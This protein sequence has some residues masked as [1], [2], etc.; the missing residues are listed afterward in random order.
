MSEM[1]CNSNKAVSEME[2]DKIVP[3][4][5]RGSS[6]DKGRHHDNA[7]AFFAGLRTSS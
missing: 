6:W 5:T 7:Q 3:R 4:I 1:H 2:L